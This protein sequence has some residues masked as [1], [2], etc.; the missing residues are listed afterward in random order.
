MISRRTGNFMIA[1]V[2]LSVE[3]LTG[4][5]VAIVWK[6]AEICMHSQSFLSISLGDL[7]RPGGEFATPTKEPDTEMVPGPS[8]AVQFADSTGLRSPPNAG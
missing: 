5:V 6:L 8:S 3:L 2:T 1:I 4:F 7:R